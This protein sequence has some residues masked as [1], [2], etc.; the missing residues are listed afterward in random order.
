MLSG[1]AHIPLTATGILR[2]RNS[3]TA[4]KRTNYGWWGRS[5]ESASTTRR[6][7]GSFVPCLGTVSGNPRG[8]SFALAVLLD[9]RLLRHPRCAVL[10]QVHE[11]RAGRDLVGLHLLEDDRSATRIP[12]APLP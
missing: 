10:E 4:P 3:T 9:Q 5:R 12:T 1:Y 7:S 2:T 6:S 8:Q 11:R